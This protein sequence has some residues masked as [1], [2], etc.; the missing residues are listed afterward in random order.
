ME[1]NSTKSG[2]IN[3]D[4]RK[5]PESLTPI[6]PSKQSATL[7]HSQEKGTASK[8]AS[9]PAESPDTLNLGQHA[10]GEA[11]ASSS[12]TPQSG[13]DDET[14][15]R[16]NI[17]AW[18]TLF[19]WFI[20]LGGLAIAFITNWVYNIAKDTQQQAERISGALELENKII[21]VKGDISRVNLQTG[22]FTFVNELDID[23][24]H[25]ERDALM[26]INVFINRTEGLLN[27]MTDLE[28]Q[29]R[30]FDGILFKLKNIMARQLDERYLNFI[31]K[32]LPQFLELL[33]TRLMQ[34]HLMESQAG[35]NCLD[36]IAKLW[37]LVQQE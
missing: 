36:D 12:P 13:N 22:I 2:G 5:K 35:R 4:N 30:Y 21:S 18:G 11:A 32:A 33:H 26:A 23:E 28:A 29:H 31:R 7:P 10:A 16:D 9:V 17:N 27:T 24:H 19:S 25:N 37:R 15:A 34:T 1:T 3:I 20:A 8:R 6:K 14:N